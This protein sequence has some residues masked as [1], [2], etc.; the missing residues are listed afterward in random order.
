MPKPIDPRSLA[1]R[2]PSRA[3]GAAFTLIELT[4]VLV[5]V[6]VIAA[7]AMPRYANSLAR[8]RVEQSAKR[9]QADLILARQL[10][11]RGSRGIRVGFVTGSA[12]NYFLA[13][14]PDPD[15]PARGNYTVDLFDEPYAATFDTISVGGDDR[16][17]FDGFGIPDTTATIM[18]LVGSERRRVVVDATGEVGIESP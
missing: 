9:L 10:A 17:I 16:L 18:L 1:V 15:R 7:I 2:A 3:R 5:L 12:S 11:I 8:Y 4:M 6:G 13:G 14:V